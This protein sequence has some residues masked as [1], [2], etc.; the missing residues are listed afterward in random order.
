MQ[1]LLSIKPEFV[2]KIF[3]GEKRFE[4]RKQIPKQ[5]FDKVFIYESS[6]T[7]NIV[8]WFSIG[9]IIKGHPNHVWKTCKSEGGIEENRYF[10]YCNGNAKMYAFEINEVHKFNEPINPFEIKKDFV[11][12]QNFAYFE[13]ASTFFNELENYSRSN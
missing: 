4:F 9:R 6:P 11:P 5:R 3:T 1:I 7:Q 2:E 12:P 10:E 8:G 13:T